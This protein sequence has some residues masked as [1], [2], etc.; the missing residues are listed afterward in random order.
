M[1]EPLPYGENN[2]DK[3]FELEDFFKTLDVGYFLEIDLRYPDKMKKN[4]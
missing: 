2:F 3:S 4:T 1:S